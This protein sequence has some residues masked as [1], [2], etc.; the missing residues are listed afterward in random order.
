MAVI[1][2]PPRPH[3]W[4]SA[5]RRGFRWIDPTPTPRNQA[6]GSEHHKTRTLRSRIHHK[7]W[8]YHV[9]RVNVCICMCVIHHIIY[10]DIVYI[11]IYYVYI[12]IMYIYIYTYH[13]H[14]YIYNYI[15]RYLIQI[16]FTYVYIWNVWIVLLH[17]ASFCITAGDPTLKRQSYGRPGTEPGW[18][19]VSNMYQTIQSLV[20]SISLIM[21]HMLMKD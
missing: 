5:S 16:S 21:F 18:K 8:K 14:I 7:Y 11:Y 4:G 1:H 13:V 17:A 6:W 9:K 10:I 20:S 15:Y 3:L 12:S 2:D 19:V